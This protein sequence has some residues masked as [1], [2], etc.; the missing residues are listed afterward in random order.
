[1]T[2]ACSS[3]K[4]LKNYFKKEKRQHIVNLKLGNDF[5]AIRIQL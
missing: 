2:C 3:T 1:M 4:D 5:M